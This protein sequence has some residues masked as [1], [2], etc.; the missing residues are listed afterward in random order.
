MRPSAR[1]RIHE[2]AEAS[3]DVGLDL[4]TAALGRFGKS[5]LRRL[6]AARQVDVADGVAQRL[7]RSAQLGSDRT[8]QPVD[9]VQG[10]VLTVGNDAEQFLE[11]LGSVC[12]GE[13]DR[14]GF[15]ILSE[16]AER[17]TNA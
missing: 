17:T 3:G 1:F 12:R 7:A 4:C 9:I 8:R 5:T 16:I 13:R 14:S 15:D 11:A 6:I 2:H 10:H